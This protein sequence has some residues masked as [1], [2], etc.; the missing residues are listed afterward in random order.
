MGQETLGLQTYL[1]EEND[2]SIYLTPQTFSDDAINPCLE[3]TYTFI[4]ILMDEVSD[5]HVIDLNDLYAQ[6][7]NVRH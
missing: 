4:N 6:Y 3:E 5:L 1:T 2:T 7:F